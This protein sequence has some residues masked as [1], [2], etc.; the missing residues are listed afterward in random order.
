MQDSLAEADLRVELSASGV[1]CTL[2]STYFSH[3]A[4]AEDAVPPHLSLKAFQS[5]MNNCVNFAKKHGL[6]YSE[7]KSKLVCI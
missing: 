7:R 4:D 5:L 3:L 6:V 2:N 1:G